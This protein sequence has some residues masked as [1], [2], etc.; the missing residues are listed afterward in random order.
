MSSCGGIRSK[1]S[2]LVNLTIPIVSTA[3]LTE[4]T[5]VVTLFYVGR[6]DGAKYIGAATLGSMMCNITGYSIMYGT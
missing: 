5:G 3:L 4:L 1:I 2:E 6:I